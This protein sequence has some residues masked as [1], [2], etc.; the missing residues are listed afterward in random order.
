MG[1]QWSSLEPT[2]VWAKKLPRTWQEE[3]LCPAAGLSPSASV[4]QVFRRVPASLIYTN[5]QAV[6][7][8]AYPTLTS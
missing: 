7:Y 1:K 2:L 3:V 6:T 5:W 4:Y 8:S